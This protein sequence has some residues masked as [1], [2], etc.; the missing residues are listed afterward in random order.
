M[1]D[2]AI[3]VGAGSGF[4]RETAR[5]VSEQGWRVV[6]VARTA[7]ALDS[8]VEEQRGSGGEIVPV[9][10]DGRDVKLAARLIAEHDPAAVLVGGGVPPH[11]APLEEQTWETLSLHWDADVR[12]AFT[13]LRSILDAPPPSLRRVVVLSSGAALNGS[14][15]SGGYAGAKSTVRWLTTASAVSS[16]SA[17]GLPLTFTCVLPQL[18]H[19]TPL[20]RV[21][22]GGYAELGGGSADAALAAP[23]PYTAADAG[24][25]IAPLLTSAEHDEHATYV[26]GPQGLVAPPS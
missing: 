26:L 13:W 5:T 4:G 9:V 17:R 2:T 6:A 3:V 24:R 7:G 8:L 18:T 11:M 19:D 15:G 10:G 1:T 14:P 16:A 20:G 22:V 12:L 21:G 25:A 23:V